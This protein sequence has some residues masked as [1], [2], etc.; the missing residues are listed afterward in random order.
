MPPSGGECSYGY[1]ACAFLSHGLTHVSPAIF[2]KSK[3][4]VAA[5][6][7]IFSLGKKFQVSSV[8]QCSDD[9]YVETGLWRKRAVSVP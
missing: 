6:F 3:V 7:L 9:R 4:S 8:S 5:C 2:L 1:Y